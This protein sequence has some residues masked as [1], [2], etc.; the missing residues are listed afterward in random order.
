MTLPES[1][2]IGGLAVSFV[3]S[4]VTVI[5]FMYRM[6][7]DV[8]EIKKQV[9]N[10]LQHIAEVEDVK[11]GRVYERLDEVKKVQDEKFVM[12]EM[13]VMQHSLLH[14]DI[15]ELKADVKVLLKR[16]GG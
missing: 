7:K 9:T 8:S 6:T 16:D 14:S 5:G 3:G 2:A 10:D 1:V 11:R 15:A 12:K 13:C 4:M